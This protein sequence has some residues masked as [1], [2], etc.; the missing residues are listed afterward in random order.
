VQQ[1][2]ANNSCAADK[3]V[4]SQMSCLKF[5]TSFVQLLHPCSVGGFMR[6]HASSP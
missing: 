3:D 5:V 2:I 4:H 1:H 6:L